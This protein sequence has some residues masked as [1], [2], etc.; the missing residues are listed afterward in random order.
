MVRL[1]WGRS[2][3]KRRAAIDV[4][5]DLNARATAPQIAQLVSD[6]HWQVR[7]SVVRVLAKWGDPTDALEQLRQDPD[8]I[9]RGCTRWS[10]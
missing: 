9:V 8:V 3:Q 1:L 10:Q 7:A 6:D 5:S 4:L 2:S